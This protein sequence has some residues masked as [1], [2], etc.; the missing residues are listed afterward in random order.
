MYNRTSGTSL[1]TEDSGLPQALCSVE[2]CSLGSSLLCGGGEG[3]R[4]TNGARTTWT[5]SCLNEQKGGGSRKESRMDR[6]HHLLLNKY[7]LSLSLHV[8]YFNMFLNIY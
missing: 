2:C 1:K 8:S 3:A 5:E 7:E 4:L 6:H